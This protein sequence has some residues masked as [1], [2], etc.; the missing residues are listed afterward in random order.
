MNPLAH[1]GPEKPQR[2]DRTQPPLVKA[3]VGEHVGIAEA[4]GGHPY[5]C[6]EVQLQA[7]VSKLYDNAA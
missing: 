1:R 7:G 5:S 4:Q 3:E 6:L 2:V